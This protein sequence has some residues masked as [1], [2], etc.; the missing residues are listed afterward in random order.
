MRSWLCLCL[1]LFSISNAHAQV[2]GGGGV[3]SFVV[4]ND[5]FARA[6]TSP[7]TLG[8]AETGQT[9]NLSGVLFTVAQIKNHAIS[10]ASGADVFYAYV[11]LSGNVIALGAVITWVN[12]GGAG[13]GGFEVIG[14]DGGGG[15]LHHMIHAVNTAN[16]NPPHITWWQDSNQNNSLSGCSWTSNWAIPSPGD[17][18]L[19][20]VTIDGN[21]YHYYQINGDGSLAKEDCIGDSHVSLLWGTGDQPIWESGSIGN[22]AI[23]PTFSQAWAYRH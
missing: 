16:G 18:W 7:G 3:P 10:A 2:I 22:N 15:L 21:N 9:W 14:S 23:S 6:D 11:N 8:T 17:K 20:S 4:L 19:V 13:T 5:T 1:F 12:G